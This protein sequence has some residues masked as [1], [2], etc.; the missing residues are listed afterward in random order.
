MNILVIQETDWIAR[1]PHTQHHL[2]ERLSL[3]G[4]TI[5]VIDYGFDWKKD[6][7]RKMFEKRAMGH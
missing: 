1:Y 5:K 6:P 2:F 4:H 3:N 7:R